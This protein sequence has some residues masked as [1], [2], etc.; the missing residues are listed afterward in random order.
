[1]KL[2]SEEE[3][4]NTIAAQAMFYGYL[5]A[6]EN[7]WNAQYVENSAETLTKINEMLHN[8]WANLCGTIYYIAQ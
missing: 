8:Q 2:S 5:Y 3:N 1:M 4:G 6:R 7:V